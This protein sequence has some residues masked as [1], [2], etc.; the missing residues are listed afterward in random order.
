MRPESPKTCCLPGIRYTAPPKGAVYISAGTQGVQ[1]VLTQVTFQGMEA[2]FAESTWGF[3][4]GVH[5]V[6]TA[7]IGIPLAGSN[8]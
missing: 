5:I 4:W 7:G 2:T 6:P 3:A 1:I 8:I